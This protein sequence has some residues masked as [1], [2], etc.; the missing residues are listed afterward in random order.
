MLHIHIYLYDISRL[1]VKHVRRVTTISAIRRSNLGAGTDWSCETNSCG[2]TVNGGS[3]DSTSEVR[4]LHVG[5]IHV[6]D[7][8]RR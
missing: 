2:R 4:R 5:I 3:V 6:M 8:K 1:R 7:V